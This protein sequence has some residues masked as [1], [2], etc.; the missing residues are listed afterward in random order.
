MRRL[1]I[2]NCRF[3]RPIKNAFA[4]GARARGDN[5]PDSRIPEST[6]HVATPLPVAIAD[7]AM[8]RVGRLLVAYSSRTIATTVKHD[9]VASARDRTIGAMVLS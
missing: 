5:D 4:L 1:C 2:S 9:R 6:S 7:Q 8:R 3:S